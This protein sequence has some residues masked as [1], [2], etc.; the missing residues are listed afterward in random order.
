[1]VPHLLISL[2]L[3]AALIVPVSRPADT[4]QYFYDEL[5]RLVGVVDGQ[6]NTA[7]YVYDEVGNLLSI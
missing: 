3:V 5:G 1:M 7:R 2:V 6:G 4:A